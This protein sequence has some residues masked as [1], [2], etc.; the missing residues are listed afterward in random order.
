MAQENARRNQ[1]PNP[2]AAETVLKSTYMDDPIDSVES[3][4][5]IVEVYRPLKALWGIACMPETFQ[6]FAQTAVDFAGPLYTVKG[7][8]KP[9]QKRWL[10]LFTCLETR[11]VHL[12]MPWGLDTDTFLNAF[13]RF[14]S[15][16]AVP[17]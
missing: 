9:R 14:T 17:K 1:Y 8:R 2:R 6:P 7:R 16:R 10:C 13:T 4:E 5:E 3:D 15:R 12:E 11:A